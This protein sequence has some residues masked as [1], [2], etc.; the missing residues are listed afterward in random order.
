MDTPTSYPDAAATLPPDDELLRRLVENSALATVVIT[1]ADQRITLVNNR[2][3]EL[4]GYTIEDVPDASHW[5]PL[6]YPDP[7]YRAEVRARWEQLVAEAAATGRPI[8]P[9]QAT[10]ICKDGAARSVEWHTSLL[11][12]VI[13]ISLVDLTHHRRTEADLKNYSERLEDMVAERTAALTAAN[14]QLQESEARFRTIIAQLGEGF[15]LIDPQGRV[16]EWNRAMEAITGVE[17]DR[18]LGQTLWDL[19][20]RLAPP[21]QSTSD[22]KQRLQAAML[23]PLHYGQPP[24]PTELVEIVFQRPDGVRFIAQQAVFPIQI[25]DA[26]F[27]GSTTQDV[28]A[29]RQAEAALRRGEERYRRLFDAVSDAIFLVDNTTGQ[30]M[31]ANAAAVALYGYS[32]EELGRLKNTDLSAEPGQTRRTTLE[33]ATWIPA[34]RHRRKDGSEFPVEVSANHF[35][36]DGRRVHLSAVRN[37]TARRQAEE[38]LRREKAFSDAVIDGL[39]GIFYLYDDQGQA[40]RWNK[41]HEELTGYTAADL[42]YPDAYLKWYEDPVERALV[43]SRIREVFTKGQSDVEAHLT[44]KDGRRIPYYLTGARLDIG[45]RTYLMGVGIDISELKRAEAA[46][47]QSEHKF[48]A[49]FDHAG[50][51]IIILDLEGHVLEVNE[52]ASERLGY[53]REEVRT[54]ASRSGDEPPHAAAF[55]RGLEELR[56]KDQVGFETTLAHRDGTSFPVEVIAR[57]IDY[58]GHPAILASARDI[59]ERKRL[60]T[61]VVQAQKMETLGRLAGGVA[62]DFNNLLTAISGYASLVKRGLSAR[63]PARADIEQVLRGAERASRLT[64]QLLAFSRRQLMEPK[65]VDLNRLILDMDKMLRRLIGENIDLSTK[66][67]PD[68][69]VILAD[70][71][72][73]E[74]VVANLVVNARD[75]MPNGGRLTLETINVALD[76]EYARQHVGVAPGDYAALTITDTG[77]GMTDEVLAHIFE[78][79]YTTKDRGKGTGLGLATVYGIVRQHQGATEVYSQPGQGTAFIVYLPLASDRRPVEPASTGE[80]ARPLPHGTETVLVVE[81]E[82]AVRLVS[83][84]TL[85]NLGYTVLEAASGEE[86]LQIFQAHAGTV[87]LLFTDVVMPHMNGK[88]LADRLIADHPR[89]K[90][91]FT[92]G[93][94]DDVIAPAGLLE[95]GVVLLPKPF[96]AYTLAHK[97]RQVLDA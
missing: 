43:E 46:L 27:L 42:A 15:A 96:T 56:H 17:R 58:D 54:M 95:G 85:K 4:T 50:D 90:V 11:G 79:F 36:L 63:D 70:P 26:V 45:D 37:I 16:T 65:R 89:L 28:T 62:H 73:I 92:S 7:A 82:A 25:G 44:V 2:C 97:L 83:V 71:G 10:V 22:F 35:D 1:T 69:S 94:T 68:A 76:E 61:Q 66:P 13:L 72:L 34:R 48:H 18:A 32:R 3:T 93:Y 49:L 60:E 41:R 31:E 24:F 86:A 21:E 75:A 29:R 52:T 30:I 91:L 55:R 84:R 80:E 38:A 33:E 51:A 67:G 81:D 19:A 39:P 14:E 5:W 40:V 77:S 57:I 78:P 6:A 8:A 9:L 59:S 88:Q 64:H 23:D 47:Q 87:N 12:G 20:E 74:Q 53:S